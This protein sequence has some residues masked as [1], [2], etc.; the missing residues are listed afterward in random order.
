MKPVDMLEKAVVFR[1]KEQNV[2]CYRIPALVRTSKGTL[3]AFCEARRRSC[4]DWAHSAIMARRCVDPINHLSKWEP[5]TVV[6][7]S[8]RVVEA[9][10]FHEI[11]EAERYA[12]LHGINSDADDYKPLIDV[13]TDNPVPI[14][15]RDGK[16]IHLVYC[17]HYDRAYY[18]QSTDDGFSWAESQ[19]ITTV[20][21]GYR[22]K[23]NWTCIAA[24][25]GHGLQVTKGPNAGRLIVPFWM[26]ANQ[27]DRGAHHPTEVVTIYSDDG[28]KT[29]QAGEFVPS[30]IKDPN[31]SQIVELE[32]GNVLIM[33]R[34]REVSTEKNPRRTRAYA[35]SPNGI[36]QWTPYQFSHDLPEPQCMGSLIRYSWA[37]DAEPGRLLYC[38]C[39][40]R[41]LP[42]AEREIRKNMGL[43]LSIDD[44]K[45]WSLSR[46]FEKG[47]AAYA[48]LAVDPE[49]GWI[50][51]LAEAQICD[52]TPRPYES[53]TIYRI[54]LKWLEEGK[55]HLKVSI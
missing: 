20:F 32:N 25:P 29:W 40:N 4:S 2:F 7:E 55:N 53:Q 38:C 15:D 14:V 45:T 50:Y 18:T 10:T 30:A 41:A 1:A 17:D 26:A 9:K 39:D 46:I 44:G 28:G 51:A 19:D 35:I 37:S 36:S 42:M 3:I 33:T 31:E 22:A 49:K 48:D 34:T 27:N 24:G 23:W 43:F 21:E 11:L 12:E 8:T 52:D 6:K 16:T 13:V 54:P 47:A 5:Q